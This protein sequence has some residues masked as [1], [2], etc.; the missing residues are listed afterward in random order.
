METVAFNSIGFHAAMILNRLRA[1]R[2]ISDYELADV[3][4]GADK[5]AD[6]RCGDAYETGHHEVSNKKLTLRSVRVEPPGGSG[7]N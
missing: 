4:A 3:E 2:Q 7:G 1:A 5:A 6:P